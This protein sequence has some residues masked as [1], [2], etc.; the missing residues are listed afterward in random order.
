[1]TMKEQLLGIPELNITE[2][3]IRMDD[4][5]LDEHVRLLNSFVDKFPKQEENIKHALG[6][7]D[8]PVLSENIMV[9]KDLL[10][11]INA[12]T[13]ANECLQH[14]NE[15]T[16]ANHEKIETYVTHFLFALTMLSIDI[17]M[18]TLKGEQGWKNQRPKK[19]AVKAEDGEISI[20]AV[21]D[22]ALSLGMLKNIL[23][24]TEYKLTCVISSR[25]ALKFLQNHQPDLF[26]LDIEMP[27]LD[28]YELAK[29][30]REGGQTAPII[31]LTANATNDSFVKAVNAGAVDFIVKPPNKKYVLA[32][33]ARY[34]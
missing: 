17:Q 18:A 20:L 5:E 9:V 2:K 34:I 10:V 7:K 31:F 15:F 22:N 14:L 24:D 8:Y 30:I 16:T 33:I 25:D 1:M 6:K 13:L 28:G 32:R 23:E 29:K 21:D 3:L 12:D 4:S 19:T 27:Q 26:I 11:Q